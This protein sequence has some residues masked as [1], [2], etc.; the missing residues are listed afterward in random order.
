MLI[1]TVNDRY[2]S[3]IKA[4][5][6]LRKTDSRMKTLGTRVIDS[7]YRFMKFEMAYDW[8]HDNEEQRKWIFCEFFDKR[9]YEDARFANRRGVGAGQISYIRAIERIAQERGF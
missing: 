2:N 5:D 8:E 4:V 1:I 6:E 9:Y 3:L 7:I